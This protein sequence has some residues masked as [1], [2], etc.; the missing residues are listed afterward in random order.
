[1]MVLAIVPSLW[2]LAEV[3]AVVSGIHNTCVDPRGNIK[4]SGEICQMINQNSS[5]IWSCLCKTHVLKEGL[6]RYQGFCL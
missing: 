5:M 6:S 1:M 4:R 3:A 2:T